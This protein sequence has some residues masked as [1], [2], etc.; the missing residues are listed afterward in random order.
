MQ[1]LHGYLLHR[2][3]LCGGLGWGDDAGVGLC[4]ALRGAHLHGGLR[5]LKELHLSRNTLGDATVRALVSI[6]DEGALARVAF[7]GLDDNAISDHGMRQLEGAL[8][9]GRLRCCRHLGLTGN[10]GLEAPVQALAMQLDEHA[11]WG[12]TAPGMVR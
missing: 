6:L 1:V 9:R 11:M 3:L 10:P 7:I 8:A 5:R 4:E 12:Q 2:R